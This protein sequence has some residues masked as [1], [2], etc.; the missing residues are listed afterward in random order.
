MMSCNTTEILTN[1]DRR[2]NLINQMA[3]T[4]PAPILNLRLNIPGPVKRHA[5]LDFVFCRFCRELKMR[6]ASENLLPL[7]EETRATK[8]GAEWTV[9]LRNPQNHAPSFIK[10]LLIQIENGDFIDNP[11]LKPCYR[12]F[13]L[14]LYLPLNKPHAQDSL[15][16]GKN[17]EEYDRKDFI[18]DQPA[19][20]I[21]PYR[22]CY[23]CGE[24]AALCARKRNHSMAE[25]SCACLALARK[26]A[27]AYEQKRLK[28]LALQAVL[29]E[30]V[31]TPKPGL[32][33][34]KNNGAH[35]DMDIFSFIKS[36]LSLEEYFAKSFLLGM[37][38]QNPERLFAEL[39]KAGK[40]AE[41][42]M[43][44]S[45]DQ[46]N[47]QKGIIFSFALILASWAAV[48]QHKIMNAENR[49]FDLNKINSDL[50]LPEREE[51]SRFIAQLGQISMRDFTGGGTRSEESNGERLYRRSGV[52]G[53]RGAAASGYKACFEAADLIRKKRLA[54][55]D[56]SVAC[57]RSLLYL[58]NEV[59]DSNLRI[60]LL[61]AGKE[62][63]LTD[64]QNRLRQASR[65]IRTERELVRFLEEF[66]VFCKQN[67]LTFGG[68]ADSLAISIFLDQ[69]F[70]RIN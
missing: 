8:C 66:D 16:F 15:L 5:L 32:V 17:Y 45:T 20:S 56:Y 50:I 33:D 43:L 27:F 23:L 9:Q 13:D 37:Q 63:L 39:R 65:T 54:G 31:I 19:C 47:T 10:Q 58:M 64:I 46:V 28:Q 11:E 14:D 52:S 38:I 62:E 41:R 51:L 12:L 34:L 59:E 24:D 68:A 36:S 55:E 22:S 44:E 1:I 69:L 29:S 57:L 35:R 7:T 25:L 49:S 67:N 70:D 4:C 53:A 6:L 60:R 26:L 18:A 2:V 3:K 30:A 61:R 40:F 21:R 48:M 42:Q